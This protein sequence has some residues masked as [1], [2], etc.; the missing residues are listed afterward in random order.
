MPKLNQIIAIEKGIKA[1]SFADITPFHHQLQKQALLT[2]IARTYRP[3]DDD[4]DKLPNES[5]RVQVRASDIITLAK[6]SLSKLFNITATKDWAN[7]VAKADVMVD[8]NILIAD[9]PVTYLLF[10]EKQL[11]DIHAFVEKLPALD[12][13]EVWHLDTTS[14]SWATE[15]IET[16]KTKKVMKNHV[17]AEATDKHPAQVEVY[18][19]D[20][21]VGNWSTIKFSGAMPA[22][23][24]ME[25]IAR[26]EKLQEA[27]KFAREEANSIETKKIETADLV[28]EYLFG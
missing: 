23:D 9:A 1:K 22:R 20:V 19:E 8:G 10:L 21:P 5:T 17:K 27:V 3:R 25:I 28:F 6:D 11:V 4:G 13:A 2:G 16:V 7:C 15:V 12:P 26:V 18:T 24:I 14:N